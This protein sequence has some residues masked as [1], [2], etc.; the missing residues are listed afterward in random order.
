MT[1]SY[2]EIQS[3]GPLEGTVAVYGAK[4]AVL[5]T[6]A[7]LLLTQGKS[8]LKN[9][10]ASSDVLHM[11]TLL[12]QLGA[13]VDFDTKEHVLEVDTSFVDKWCIAPSIMKKMRASILVMGPLLARFS[14]AQIALPGGC[15]IGTRPIDYHL[16]NFAKIGVTFNQD[17]D[18]LNASVS[19]LKGCDLV[20]EYPSVG[21]TENLMMAAVCA[22]GVTRIINAALEPEVLDL[23]VVLNKMGASIEIEAPATICIQGGTPLRPIHHEIIPDRLEA[24]ALACAAAITGGSVKITDARPTEMAVFLLKLEQMGHRVKIEKNAL[25]VSGCKEPRAVSYKTSPYPGF[26]TDM[27]APMM[28]LQSIAQGSSTIYETVFENRLLHVRE[29]QKMGAQITIEGN[30]ASVKGVDELY[31]THVI[32]SD[33]RASCALVLAGLVAQGVTVMTG[34]NHW[35]R[36]YESLENK[37]ALLGADIALKQVTDK[38]LEHIQKKLVKQGGYQ[39]P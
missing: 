35:R 3:N 20:L 19:R 29:L 26:P 18:F 1:T 10:P 4:N 8:I 28:A 21:A 31:G 34:L 27:Q 11:I 14:Q 13:T 22:Q 16:Q 12:E 5:V 33:I 17:G 2:L 36:G 32:A 38:Q 23:I 25:I 7:S 30:C 6:M 9:V 24:G 15:V 37:L 39:L